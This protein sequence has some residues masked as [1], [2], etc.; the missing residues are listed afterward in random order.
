MASHPPK[1]VCCTRYN[2][3]EGTPRGKM[4]TLEDG[5]TQ[6]YIVSP[7]DSRKEK[8]KCGIVYVADIFGIFQN[9]KL[10]ADCYA[11][12]GYT[13]ILPDLF[14]GD[15]IPEDKPL[16]FDIP[17]WF[18]TGI[19]GGNPHTPE[20]VDPIIL[21][22]VK[23]LKSQGI[24][25]VGGAGYCFGAK[26][27]V[28]NYKAGIDIGYMAHPSFVTEEELAA[29]S[30]PLAI[31]ASE[32]DIV[33]SPEM[34]HKSEEILMATGLPYQLYLFQGVEHGF[35]VRG[36]LSKKAVKFAKEQAF[37]QA[38]AWFDEYLYTSV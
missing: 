33:F 12:E 4:I 23:T 15:Q 34:R 26:Y 8:A 5:K 16:D 1:N 29:I 20:E 2:L 7:V 19:N 14:N 30:G 13:T 38:I 37:K 18:I 28:R 36:D 35:A 31:S 3:H 11:D 32:V 24:E 25:R 10:M 27:V 9:S 17:K 22:A 6:A 21:S